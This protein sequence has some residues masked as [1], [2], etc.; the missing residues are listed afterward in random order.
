MPGAGITD[1]QDRQGH[2]GHK[3]TTKEKNFEVASTVDKSHSDR[4]CLGAVPTQWWSGALGGS[5]TFEL[6]LEP[7]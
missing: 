7:L 3:Q 6:R 2:C 1:K 4:L 5:D